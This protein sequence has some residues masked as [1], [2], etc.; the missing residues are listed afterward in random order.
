MKRE[1]QLANV[2]QY[3]ILRQRCLARVRI[4]LKFFGILTVTRNLKDISRSNRTLTSIKTSRAVHENTGMVSEAIRLMVFWIRRGTRSLFSLIGRAGY[5]LKQD[6]VLLGLLET[7]GAR[8]N[9]SFSKVR[10]NHPSPFSIFSHFDIS[11]DVCGKLEGEGIVGSSIKDK[12]DLRCCVERLSAP[13]EANPMDWKPLQ[14]WKEPIHRLLNSPNPGV[15]NI[16]IGTEQS[17]PPKVRKVRSLAR[18]LDPPFML[19]LA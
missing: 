8:K 1:H 5:I 15:G 9:P 11:A 4:C 6:R 12:L 19:S 18:V 10:P 13:A 14:D 17:G 3:L 7:S 16:R 2:T